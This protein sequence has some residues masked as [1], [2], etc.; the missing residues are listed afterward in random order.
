[1]GASWT[2]SW[3]DE[4]KCQKVSLTSA[5]PEVLLQPRWHIPPSIWLFYRFST[6]AWTLAWCVHSG[7]LF[8]SPKCLFLLSYLTYC[9]LALYSFIA[10]INLISAYIIIKGF[11]K[12]VV[13]E[14]RPGGSR[15]NWAS[16]PFP[17]S[18]AKSLRAQW[19]FQ[20]VSAAFSLI[21]SFLYWTIHF[22]L[23]RYP[24]RAFNMNLDYINSCLVALDILLSSTPVHLCH[25]VYLMA[26]WSL[27]VIF[28]LI[29]WLSSITTLSG[30][31]YIYREL[32][33]I[34]RPFTTA[35]FVLCFY[36]LFIPA[37]QFILWNVQLLRERILGG[38]FGR[39]FG[40]RREAWWWSSVGGLPLRLAPAVESSSSVFGS[41][42]GEMSRIHSNIQT[43]ATHSV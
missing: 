32:D 17:D 40:L 31:P 28:A 43:T 9:L 20:V 19:L 2:Q 14:I 11:F 4:F 10:L 12:K 42:R 34:G 37:S 27:Y 3:R 39:W 7:L 21:V 1:M 16:L 6:F 29:I 33:F 41:R 25:Y 24:L 38:P 30:Q 5:T 18:L 36:V 22:P 8:G 15:E 13:K 26:A 23:A 35:F